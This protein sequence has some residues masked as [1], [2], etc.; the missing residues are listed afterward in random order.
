MPLT[1]PLA[2]VHCR[3]SADFVR[4]RR[5]R[6][7]RTNGHAPPAARGVQAQRFQCTWALQCAAALAAAAAVPLWLGPPRRRPCHLQHTPAFA[8]AAA[9]QATAA[10]DSLSSVLPPPLVTLLAMVPPS[11]H[12]LHHLVPGR[13]CPE[14]QAV[15]AWL[16]LVGYCVPQV[17]HEKLR[18]ASMA[19]WVVLCASSLGPVREYRC[20]RGTSVVLFSERG[21]LAI[22]GELHLGW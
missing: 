22:G 7:P 18:A 14:S 8:S 10:M 15:R 1:S 3:A 20:R 2:A 4:L 6:L 13:V 19:G 9:S 16:A 12:P 17:S 11:R 5:L 21:G